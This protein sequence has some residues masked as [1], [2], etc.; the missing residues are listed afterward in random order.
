M[1]VVKER[2]AKEG[3]KSA[4]GSASGRLRVSLDIAPPALTD[5]RKARM[6]RGALGAVILQASDHPRL[7]T[8]P[9]PSLSV[10]R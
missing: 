5:A 8:G 10:T 9:T 6:F 1:S 3:R 4:V 7:A 2:I